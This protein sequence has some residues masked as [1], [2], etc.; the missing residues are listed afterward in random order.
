MLILTLAVLQGVAFPAQ[1]SSVENLDFSSGTLDG[2]EGQGF[3]LMATD[4]SGV[5]PGRFVTSSD[6][7]PGGR[8]AVLHRAFVVPMDTAYILFNADPA[9]GQETAEQGKL[10]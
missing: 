4:R 7:G 2:W 8:R 10:D 1:V 5:Y 9:T 3:R 6:P